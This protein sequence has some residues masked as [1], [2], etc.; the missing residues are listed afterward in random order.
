MTTDLA[1]AD[2]KTDI[3]DAARLMAQRHI[4]HLPVL[5][6]GGSSGSSPSAT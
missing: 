6:R 3:A 5:D 2:P 4:R 1:T